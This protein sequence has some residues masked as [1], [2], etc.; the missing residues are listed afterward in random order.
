MSTHPHLQNETNGRTLI[1][2]ELLAL[3][4]AM[5]P[6]LVGSWAAAR[7]FSPARRRRPAWEA[8]VLASGRRGAVRAPEGSLP[9]WTWGAGPSVVLVHG[10]EGRG[11][12]LGAV[13]DTLVAGGR[14]VVAFDA[15]GHG[16][17]PGRTASVIELA[18]ALTLVATQT[19][20]VE[21]IVAHSLGAAATMVALARADLARKAVF[22][23]PP[24]AAA[25]WADGFARRVGLP[26]RV[27]RAFRRGLVE[28]LGV[29]VETID[30]RVLRPLGAVDLLVVHDATDREVPVELGREV[31]SAWGGR[32]VETRGLGH[33]RILRSPRLAD[34]V[35]AFLSGRA[36][37][38]PQA[39]LEGE[40]FHR[41]RR[42]DGL[43]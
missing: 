29:P 39:E 40:L 30:A 26:E 12:Q 43:H 7:F 42:W 13:V 21:A 20:D 34:E 27:E 36:P 6:K 18:R 19:P 31:A 8:A 16:D 28:R 11:S 37:E 32:L 14:S 17:A 38:G 1:A 2:R 15:P 24:L 10:W 22:V 5:A 33:R 4:D 23:A 9:T 3:G 41:E 25:P 35:V